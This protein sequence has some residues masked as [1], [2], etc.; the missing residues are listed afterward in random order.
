MADRK[1]STQ[2]GEKVTSQHTGLQA[3]RKKTAQKKTAV[4]QMQSA[5]TGKQSAA[6]RS[7]D[8]VLETQHHTGNNWRCSRNSYWYDG[9]N[10][11]KFLQFYEIYGATWIRPW[12]SICATARVRFNALASSLV[13]HTCQPSGGWLREVVPAQADRQ[14][15]GKTGS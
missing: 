12:S 11:L 13:R 6:G 4:L 1:R 7:S 14:Y 15:Q 3:W 8:R 10:P 2:R 9:L 5:V